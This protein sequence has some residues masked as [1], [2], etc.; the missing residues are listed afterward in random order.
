[1]SVRERLKEIA[2]YGLGRC[3]CNRGVCIVPKISRDNH[4]G[5]ARDSSRDLKILH[6]KP[7][8]KKET[9]GCCLSNIM[10]SSIEGNINENVPIESE[11]HRY[12]LSVLDSVHP[13]DLP[14]ET[15]NA[16]DLK[17]RRLRSN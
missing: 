10:E 7:S 6:C 1:M 15:F 14:I 11:N 2:Q 5:L 4:L 16:V 8:R 9:L 12:F 13:P 17:K 3:C